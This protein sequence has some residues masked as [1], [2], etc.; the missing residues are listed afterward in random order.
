MGKYLTKFQNHSAY[1]E[2][3]GELLIPNVSLCVNENEVH[4]RKSR[5]L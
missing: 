1:E 5:P 2:K 4:Y 3:V